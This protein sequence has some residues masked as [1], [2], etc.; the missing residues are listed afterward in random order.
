MLF[1]ATLDGEVG[2]LARAYTSNPSIS[3]RPRRDVEQ[4]EVDHTFVWVTADGK[5]DTLIEEL[6]AERGLALVFVR[7]KRGAD[8]LAEKLH[9]RDVPAVALHGD[10]SQSAARAGARPLPR[11]QGDDA[12]RN[13]RRRPRARPD[14]HHARDQLRPAGGRHELRPPRR[15]HRSRRPRRHRDH[16]RPARAAGGRQPGRDAARP[17]ASSSSAR[18]CGSP[19]R[20]A[21]TRAEGG[22]RSKW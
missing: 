16:L 17:R 19:R 4:G 21:S 14:G 9:R 18:A 8:R 22:R 6:E 11:R 3:R 10:M 20:S 5:L 13:R 15:P 1:S 2:E 7:T 12:R